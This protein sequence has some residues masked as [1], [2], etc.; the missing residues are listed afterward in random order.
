MG[1]AGKTRPAVMRQ[2]AA[3]AV[4]EAV[5]AMSGFG[6]TFNSK[7][8]LTVWVVRE[9]GGMPEQIGRTPSAK[10]IVIPRCASWFVEPASN[11][12]MRALAEEIASKGLPG[13]RLAGATD[14]DLAHLK[15]LT[16]LRELNLYGTEI[17]DAGLAH[18]KGLTRLRKL[19]L[20]ELHVWGI[21]I[22]D[23]GLAHL[24]GLSGRSEE[25]KSEIK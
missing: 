25:H 1:G 24:K 5:V 2:V 19:H 14:G 11:S 15:G 16:G 21:K 3:G 23:A 22:T 20:Q 13:L 6:C 12:D 18:L 10:P 9:A 7:L 8:P 17:T 4:V